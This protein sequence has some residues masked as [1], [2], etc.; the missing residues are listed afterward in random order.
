MSTVEALGT[1]VLGLLV[2]I[3]G[4]VILMLVIF[5]MSAVFKSAGRK[6]VP[7]AAQAGAGP[8]DAAPAL[9]TASGTCG[10]V[11]LNNVPERTAAMIMAITADELKIPINELR[12]ISIRE[13]TEERQEA[14]DEI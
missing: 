7:E 6:A 8:E 1:A 5:L 10:E 14:A 2:V 13:I 11:K 9:I 4:L 12:F 3:A